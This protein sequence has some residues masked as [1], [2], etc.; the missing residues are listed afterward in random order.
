MGKRSCRGLS[1]QLHQ[2]CDEVDWC[3]SKS[4]KLIH[5]MRSIGEKELVDDTYTSNSIFINQSHNISFVHECIQ[6]VHAIHP[7]FLAH[8]RIQPQPNN[9]SITH[10]FHVI[11]KTHFVTLHTVDA[12]LITQ[13]SMILGSW[14]R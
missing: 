3:L 13:I 5:H 6:Y 2:G 9:P 4:R 1:Q 8:L 14:F 11:Q 12:I 10:R 7:I